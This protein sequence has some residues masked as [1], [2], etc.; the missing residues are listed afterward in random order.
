MVICETLTALGIDVRQPH[1]LQ[2]DMAYLRELRLGS[3]MMTARVKITIAGTI[4]SAGLYVLWL[5][6][7][8]AFKLE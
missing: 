6:I 5:G 7:K 8:Q 3:E 1:D 2:R 4:I